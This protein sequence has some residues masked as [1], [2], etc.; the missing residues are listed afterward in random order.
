ME[1]YTLCLHKREKKMKIKS[2]FNLGIL[3]A[4]QITEIFEN[5]R[6]NSIFSSI[7]DTKL[8]EGFWLA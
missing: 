8:D 5:L 6:G 7:T 1:K 3:L 4:S 2:H